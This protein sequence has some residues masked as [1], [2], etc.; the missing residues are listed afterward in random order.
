MYSSNNYIETSTKCF[1]VFTGVPAMLMIILQHLGSWYGQ[2]LLWPF[3]WPAGH[4]T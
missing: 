3:I 4:T 2:G 1:I